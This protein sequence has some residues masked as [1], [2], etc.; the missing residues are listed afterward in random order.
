MG[1]VNRSR[2]RGRPR[3]GTGGPEL[4]KQRILDAATAEFAQNGFGGAR[5]NEIARRADTNKRMLYH[6]FGGKDGLY[7]AVLED[8]YG[9]FRMAERKLSIDDLAPDEGVRRLVE[10]TFDYCAENPRFIALLNNENLYRGRHVRKSARVRSLYSPLIETIERLLERGSKDGTFRNG[11]DPVRFYISVASLAY[12]YFSNVHTLSAAFGRDFTAAAE[13]KAQR[14]HVVDL[15]LSAL[16][17]DRGGRL[18][19]K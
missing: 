18:A 19:R 15:V 4:S 1:G 7:V 11:I 2:R 5:I 6:Y 8:A 17:L 10:F 12:F 13:R 16:R 14:R 3:R 9:A